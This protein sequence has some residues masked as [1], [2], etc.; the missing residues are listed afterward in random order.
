MY[1]VTSMP[2][3]SRTRHTLR[4]AEFGFL[5]VVVKTL[6]HTPLLNGDG[7]STGRFFNVF[8]ENVSAGDF[9]FAFWGFRPY[10]ISCLIVGISIKTTRATRFVILSHR[11]SHVNPICADL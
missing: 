1:A 5:G 2:F 6:R 3:V 9:A 8:I 11:L 4:N 10:L 7:E